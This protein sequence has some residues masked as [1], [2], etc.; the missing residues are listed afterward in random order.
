MLLIPEPQLRG[1]TEHP[2]CEERQ[3]NGISHLRSFK[4]KQPPAAG[5]YHI[6]W[7]DSKP[8]NTPKKFIP[9]LYFKGLKNTKYTQ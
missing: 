8:T 6:G 2:R 9:L 4:F 3:K 7:Y 5:G 1:A